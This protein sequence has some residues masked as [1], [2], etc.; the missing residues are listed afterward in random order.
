MIRMF[1]ANTFAARTFRN[2][3]FRPRAPA[4]RPVDVRYLLAD[5]WLAYDD[6]ADYHEA[7][8]PFVPPFRIAWLYGFGCRP[9]APPP[10]APT[11]THVADVLII[12]ATGRT[13]FDST[14]AVSST[15]SPEAGFAMKDWGDRLRIYEWITDSAVCRIVVHTKWDPDLSPAPRDYPIHLIPLVATLD[16]RAV[17]RM[18]KR[19]KSL[20]AILDRTT[21]TPVD[22]VAGYNMQLAHA[23]PVTTVG[24]RVTQQISWH[25]VA[26]AGLGIYPG[27][28]T[29]PLL[30]RQINGVRPTPSGDFYMAATD[31]YWIRQPVEIVSDAPRLTLPQSVL[32]PAWASQLQ[33]G[34]DCKPC[35]DCSDYLNVATYMNKVQGQYVIIGQAAESAR[36]TYNDVRTQWLSQGDC[37]LQR[38]IRIAMQP[39][40]CPFLDVAVQY[41]NHTGSCQRDLRLFIHFNWQTEIYGFVRPV[42]GYAWIRGLTRIPGRTTSIVERLTLQGEFGRY[43]IDWPEVEPGETAWAQFRLEFPN[44]GCSN[45]PGTPPYDDCRPVTV[46][47]C[48]TGQIG[49]DQITVPFIQPGGGT[50]YAAAQD[51]TSATLRCPAVAS[52]AV[53]LTYTIPGA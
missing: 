6:P 19:V 46:E 28:N 16:E 48:V 14:L 45:K 13:V 11:P 29:E 15:L 2:A 30:V 1:Q 40:T 33:L 41:C 38:P 8:Q 49:E 10:W 27:C 51:C 7:V 5:A 9:A 4:A 43:Y 20:T 17:E 31:C 34:A 22:F 32:H 37:Y 26:G 47:G 44:W 52:D 50:G 36:D 12:D 23:G 3:A 24:G 39:Q 53:N 25:A 42:P 35:C 18:P 21:R